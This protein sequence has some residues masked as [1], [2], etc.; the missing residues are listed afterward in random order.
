MRERTRVYATH[1][2]LFLFNYLVSVSYLYP[3]DFD[4]YIYSLFHLIRFILVVLLYF[5]CSINSKFHYLVCDSHLWLMG[6]NHIVFEILLTK[7]IWMSIICIWFK[8]IS[9][10]LVIN[11]SCMI[12]LKSEKNIYVNIMS[13][14]YFGYR[15]EVIWFL[16][17]EISNLQ[18]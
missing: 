18:N 7:F 10:S 6:L 3:V 1:Y 12:L 11:L 17:W 2:W 9:N 16:I 4:A 15:I 8:L 13:Y 5:F 14:K